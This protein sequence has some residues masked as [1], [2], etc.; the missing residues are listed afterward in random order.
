MGDV[1]NFRQAR[2]DMARKQ[3]ESAAARNRAS[4]G[5]KKADKQRDAAVTELAQRRLDSHRREAP[6]DNGDAPA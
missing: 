6:D 3:K 1:I 4:L 2:K 5:R